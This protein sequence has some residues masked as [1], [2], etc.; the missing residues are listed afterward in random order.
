VVEMLVRARAQPGRPIP[1][2]LVVEPHSRPMHSRSR[3]STANSIAM[4]SR[5][6]RPDQPDPR[7]VNPPG[8]RGSGQIP[9]VVIESQNLAP[10][11]GDPRR[12]WAWF[13]ARSGPWRI[14]GR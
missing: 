11:P 1:D 12:G 13:L 2:A 14:S 3:P 10:K 8:R 5:R 4:G 7:G 6:R 9:A